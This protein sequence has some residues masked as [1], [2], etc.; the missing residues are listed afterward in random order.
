MMDPPKEI[1]LVSGI[2]GSDTD[3]PSCTSASGSQGVLDI[4]GSYLDHGS[5]SAEWWAHE[6]CSLGGVLIASQWQTLHCRV[7]ACVAACSSGLSIHPLLA[8][9]S[10]QE[11]QILVHEGFNE[12]DAEGALAASDCGALLQVLEQRHVREKG[13]HHSPPSSHKHLLPTIPETI[14][15]RE[16]LQLHCTFF[17]FGKRFHNCYEFH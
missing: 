16:P 10:W 9:L 7:F 14:L 11:V 4:L 12:R 8:P 5:A 1:E 17:C 13:T 2:H 6:A 15:L 3:L